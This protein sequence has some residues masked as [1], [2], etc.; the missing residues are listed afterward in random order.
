[1]DDDERDMLKACAW[2]ALA[3]AIYV[4]AMILVS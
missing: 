1:M 3:G 2:L 4:G